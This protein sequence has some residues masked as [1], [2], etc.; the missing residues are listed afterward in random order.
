MYE[1]RSKNEDGTYSAITAYTVSN[2]DKTAPMPLITTAGDILTVDWNDAADNGTAGVTGYNF[3]YGNSAT[4]TGKGEFTDTSIID[5]TGLE[6]GTWYFQFQS[7]DAAGNVS[8][9]SEVHSY[10]ISAVVPG[11]S[12]LNGS[13][14]GLSWE[15]AANSVSVAGCANVTLR[16]D[17]DADLPAGAF[18]GESSDKVF[19]DKAMLA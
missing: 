7:V 12:N 5:V 10:T 1:F 16:F 15:D 3:R 4:L 18:E 13:A 17:A 2:I 14:E 19:E 6:E 9:W 8:A 11:L